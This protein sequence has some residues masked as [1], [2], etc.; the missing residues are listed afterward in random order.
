MPPRKRTSTK[1]GEHTPL[2]PRHRRVSRPDP[3][4]GDVG[5][6]E[7]DV[8]AALRREEKTWNSVRQAMES[9]AD[10]R[11][12]ALGSLDGGGSRSLTSFGVASGPGQD[13]NAILGPPMRTIHG[14]Y[15]TLS[16]VHQVKTQ[17]ILDRIHP[18][19]EVINQSQLLLFL[20]AHAGGGSRRSRRLAGPSL[21]PAPVKA[22]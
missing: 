12:N 1:R 3:V 16:G 8:Q 21:T 2:A 20:P 9:L 7:A 11:R 4:D 14:T 19:V 17:S 18:D 15:R 22:R 13:S 10:I 5:V 6:E